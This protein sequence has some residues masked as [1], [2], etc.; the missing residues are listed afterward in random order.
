MV[1]DLTLGIDLG[2]TQLRAAVLNAK[3]EI[4]RRKAVATDVVGGPHAVIAQMVQLTADV[5]GDWRDRLR[6]AGVSSPGPL[7]LE[8]GRASDLPTL[9]GWFG[10]PLRDMLREKLDLPVVL[11]ND[12]VAAA[13]GEWKYGAG[14]GLANM[15]YVTVSTG[16]G[17]GVVMDGHLLHGRR[18]MAGHIGHMMIDP[19]G[20]I[21]GCGGR[22]CFEG[23]A[24]GPA[25]AMKAQAQGFA[26]GKAAFKQARLGNATAK[27]LVDEEAEW[28]GFG[29]CS[30]LHLY[31]PDVIVVGGGLSSGL[32]LMM[33]GIQYQIGKHAMTAFKAVP[34]VAAVLGDNA[35]LV[36]V[37][38][39]AME[40]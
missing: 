34:V 6:A 10:F 22:G 7:D 33:P 2:G 40:L 23:I 30:L 14:R 16:I 26:D 32:D 17:G 25:F 12:G 9:P 11:E 36:G 4:L 37:A 5:S 19:N 3:G 21:C 31:S 20:P 24:A 13:N 1:Q 8:N 29:F 39:L 15:V 18:G 35:G 28:L 38:A 27:A